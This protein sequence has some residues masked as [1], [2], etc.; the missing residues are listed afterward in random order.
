MAEIKVE[1]KNRPVW[2]W[3]LGILLL[4]AVI[5]IIADDD[6]EPVEQIGT[7]YEEPMNEADNFGDNDQNARDAR[8]AAMAYVNFVN[9][10]NEEITTDHEYSQQALTHL[11][12]ALNSIA[13]QSNV[14]IED[15]QKLDEL[16]QKADRLVQNKDSKK[17]ADMLA[18]AF[19]SAANIIQ[20]LQQKEF[21]ELKEKA[22]DVKNAANN[23]KPNV[24]VTNQKDAVKN[25]F[26]K[27][28]DAVKSMAENGSR[29]EDV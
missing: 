10:N 15:K 28:A 8:G 9:E 4:A 16:R 19:A 18:D 23:V 26:D 22:E 29:N 12:R 1:K 13:N 5:W 17:H 11:S 3:I 2:P 20:N 27:S 6:R 7:V 14:S 25:F 24:V 21:P